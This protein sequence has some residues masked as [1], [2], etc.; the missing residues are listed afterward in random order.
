M[1]RV[2]TQGSCIKSVPH[3]KGEFVLRSKEKQ[4]AERLANAE[5]SFA[6]AQLRAETSANAARKAPAKH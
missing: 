5:L 4:K 2:C 6:F 3:S 1:L